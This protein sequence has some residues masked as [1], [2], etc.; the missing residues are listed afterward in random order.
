MEKI[1][2]SSSSSLK[3]R[4]H[5]SHEEVEVFDEE[6]GSKLEITP[7]KK[8]C[9]YCGVE[10]VTYVE[11]ELSPLFWVAGLGTFLILGFYGL[12]LLPIAYFLMK[13]AVH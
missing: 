10:V 4:K 12:I 6:D 7:M 5:L 1:E 2:D 13:N 8:L 9:P 11:H 3:A